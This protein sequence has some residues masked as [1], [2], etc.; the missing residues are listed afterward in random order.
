MFCKV[1]SLRGQSIFQC[2]QE[3]EHLNLWITRKQ[4]LQE[5][6][7]GANGQRSII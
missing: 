4:T 7:F 5:S 3:Q 2:L 6:T 1:V